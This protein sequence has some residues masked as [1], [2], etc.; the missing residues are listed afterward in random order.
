MDT[1]RAGSSQW[2]EPR[3]RAYLIRANFELEPART[4]LILARAGYLTASSPISTHSTATDQPPPTPS[5]SQRPSSRLILT[6]RAP[7]QQIG[8]VGGPWQ[9][10]V[11]HRSQIRVLLTNRTMSRRRSTRKQVDDGGCSPYIEFPHKRRIISREQVAEQQGVDA[12]E[13]YDSGTEADTE[14][15]VEGTAGDGT[16]IHSDHDDPEGADSAA[17]AVLNSSSGLSE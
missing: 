3:A 1:G 15:D 6:K 9:K 7:V 16:E 12:I 13:D 5:N 11:R 14:S 10:W 2:L 17:K 4:M 8:H